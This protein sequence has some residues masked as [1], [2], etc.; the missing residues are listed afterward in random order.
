MDNYRL[1]VVTDNL[2]HEPN[3][4]LS[5]VMDN[6]WHEPITMAPFFP[7]AHGGWGARGAGHRGVCAPEPGACA[8]TPCVYSVCA[9]LCVFVRVTLCF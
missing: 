9:C 4:R 1:S 2:W 3:Y 8:C 5:V 6:L 7:G